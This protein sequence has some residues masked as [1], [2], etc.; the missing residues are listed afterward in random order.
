MLRL[1]N[2]LRFIV[3][4]LRGLLASNLRL[5]RDILWASSSRIRPELI[6]LRI[7][8]M[9][10]IALLTLTN[11]ISMAPGTLT[12]DVSNDRQKILVHALYPDSKQQLEQEFLPL[13]YRLML[14]RRC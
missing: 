2:I 7:E 11:A 1:F 5:A 12:V 6:E 10:D 8:P 14:G 3:F 4:Y 13:F 9:G